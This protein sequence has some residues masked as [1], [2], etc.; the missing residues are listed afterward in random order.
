[1]N[2]F[3][4]DSPGQGDWIYKNLTRKIRCILTEKQSKAG[5]VGIGNKAGKH[6]AAE[7]FPSAWEMK[8]S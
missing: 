7:C 2:M 1:M 4:A 3:A 8:T 5:P 6:Q